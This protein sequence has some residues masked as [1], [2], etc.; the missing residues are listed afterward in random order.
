MNRLLPH[1]PPEGFLQFE[2]AWGE[3]FQ[4]EQQTSIQKQVQE[5]LHDGTLRGCGTCR[6]MM[7]SVYWLHRDNASYIS[8]MDCTCGQTPHQTLSGESIKTPNP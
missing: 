3:E 6:M 8:F 1:K 4:K 7:G 2:L 5:A